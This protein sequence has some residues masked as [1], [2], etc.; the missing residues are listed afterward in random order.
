M[1]WLAWAASGPLPEAVYQICRDLAASGLF[2]LT[3][4]VIGAAYVSIPI[5][6]LLYLRRRP[7]LNHRWVFWAFILFIFGCGLTHF[8]HVIVLS[9]PSWFPLTMVVHL[10]TA[11]ISV[12]TAVALWPMLPHFVKIPSPTQFMRLLEERDVALANLT[13]HRARL[14]SDKDLLMRELNHRVRNNLQIVESVMRLQ[15]KELKDLASQKVLDDALNRIRAIAR[16]HENIYASDAAPVHTDTASFL[17]GIC[18]DL[19]EQFGATITVDI[20]PMQVTVDESVPMAMII[21][22]LVT[23]AVKYGRSADGRVEVHVSLKKGPENTWRLTVFDRGPGLNPDIVAEPRSFGMRL[24][25]NLSRQL[26]GALRV[27]SGAQGTTFS[28][29]GTRYAH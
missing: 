19:A 16:V 22:E 20:D 23:N 10:F 5:V 24:I 8:T 12:A 9:D 21:N 27:D 18:R 13:E 28:I 2:Q 3:N 4:L 1:S 17:A 29:E 14:Y 25:K 26:G 7:D 11:A 6:I 15:Q